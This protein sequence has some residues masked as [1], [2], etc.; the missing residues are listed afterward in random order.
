MIDVNDRYD[1]KRPQLIIQPEAFDSW[2]FTSRSVAARRLQGRRLRAGA[3]QSVVPLQPHAVPGRQ[4]LRRHLRRP[5]RGDRQA[6]QAG[7]LASSR[8]ARRGSGRTPTAASSPS[9]RGSSTIRRRPDAQRQRRAALGRVR[10]AR[11]CPAPVCR[12]SR[13][14][15]PARAR[16]AIASRFCSSTSTLPDGEPLP[17]RDAGA[18]RR[19]PRSAPARFPFGPRAGEQRHPRIAVHGADRV[20]RSGR[21]RATAS[22]TIYLAVSHDGGDHFTV[23]ARQRQCARR[24]H[25]AASRRRVARAAARSF[26][27]WQEFCTARRRRLR[28]HQVGAL[29]RRRSTRS[30]PTCASTRRGRRRQV[31]PRARRRPRRQSARRLGRRARSLA[32][33]PAARAHLLQPRPRRRRAHGPQR[34]R[35]PRRADRRR[36]RAR[37]QVGAE[38]GRAAR[39]FFVA[40]DRFPQLSMGHLHEPLAHR[41]RASRPTGASTTRASPSASTIIRRWRSTAAAR[42]TP[43]GPIAAARSPTPT[44]ATRAAPT[45][46]ATSA[47]RAVRSTPAPDRGQ[48]VAPGARVS[49]A[50]TCSSPGRTTAS[51][52]TTSSSPAA[53]TAA[54]PSSPTSASTTAATIPAI[55]TAPTSPSTRAIPPTS[56]WEDERF[57]PVGDRHRE[58]ALTAKP[59]GP[60]ARPGLASVG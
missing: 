44:S 35:R 49:T 37:Q 28:P 57:G 46:A 45:A 21:T 43:S 42:C 19:R 11:C 54:S 47:R 14:T 41:R 26:V 8:G 56:L 16:T 29:R 24:G 48:P 2:A 25:R 33:R 1:A 40:L 52:T 15:A 17:S 7:A 55:R 27:A 22:R 38:R 32:A 9:R 34:A 31:E 53:A 30:A 50:T 60:A 6:A 10:R 18:A 58:N 4:P 3:A 20:R 5:G 36:D 23:H 13:R 51:A 39:P 59:R 12:A